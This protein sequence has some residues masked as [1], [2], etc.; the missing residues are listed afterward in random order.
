MSFMLADCYNFEQSLY[1]WK[2]PIKTITN[3]MLLNCDKIKDFPA[4]WIE[5]QEEL[6]SSGL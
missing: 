2:I 5:S 1:E 6:L 3:N 4:D